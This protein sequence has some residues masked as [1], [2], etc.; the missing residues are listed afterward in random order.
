M[1]QFHSV[2]KFAASL[3]LRV[4]WKNTLTPSGYSYDDRTIAPRGLASIWGGPCPVLNIVVHEC[5]HYLVADSRRR[6]WPN[7]GLGP[8]PQGESFGE[9]PPPSHGLE[10]DRTVEESFASVLHIILVRE[11]AG[12]HEARMTMMTLGLSHTY[13]FSTR[14][15]L[16]TQ[17]RAVRAL[18]RLGLLDSKSQF[19]HPAKETNPQCP[20]KTAV[21]SASPTSP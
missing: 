15:M 18:R 17:P 12:E 11:L 8:S 4:L 2:Q 20:K 13:K 9:T 16:R 19:V 21:R 5:A 14:T 6:D 3:G 7:Y 10:V 1:L